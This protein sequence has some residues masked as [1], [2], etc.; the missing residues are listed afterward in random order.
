[1]EEE[2]K[3]KRQFRWKINHSMENPLYLVSP[4]PLFL[5]KEQIIHP[6]SLWS[7][8][9]L[10]NDAPVYPFHGSPIVV[11][12]DPFFSFLHFSLSLLFCSLLPLSFFLRFAKPPEKYMSGLNKAQL[13]WRRDIPSLQLGCTNGNGRESE[14]SERAVDEPLRIRKDRKRG[15]GKL[16]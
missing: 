6:P 15:S 13:A 16:S 1:M 8:S 7:A 2:R 4:L 12:P 11:C 14:K 10:V 3:R 9:G 5:T